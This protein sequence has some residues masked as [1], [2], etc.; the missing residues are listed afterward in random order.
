[1]RNVYNAK[2][3]REFYIVLELVGGV[4]VDDINKIRVD[5]IRNWLA[6]TVLSQAVRHVAVEV[7]KVV[8]L[9]EHGV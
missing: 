2:R 5:I 9:E 4:H 6:L 8:L 3:A 7:R 1:V